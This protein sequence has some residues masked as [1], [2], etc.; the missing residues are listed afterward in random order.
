[1]SYLEKAQAL[2]AM[3]GEGRI[4]EAYDQFYHANTTKVEAT[5]DVSQ[6]L[7]TQKELY[8]QWANSIQ[9]RHGGGVTAITADEANGITCVESW[10]D[11]T[12]HNG[13]RIKMEE[14]AVQKWEGDKIIHE[15]FY[16][17]PGPMMAGQ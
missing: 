13:P 1:M 17:N 11:I 6:G 4:M 15:R 12:F 2:Y 10:V 14:V 8:G 16:Y 7:D 3:V 5:G 9:E